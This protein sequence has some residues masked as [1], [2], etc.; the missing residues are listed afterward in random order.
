M[1]YVEAAQRRRD[2]EKRHQGGTAFVIDVTQA[3]P[4]IWVSASPL[5]YVYG[6]VY[7]LSHQADYY[8]GWGLHARFILLE[9]AVM[10]CLAEELYCSL[11]FHDGKTD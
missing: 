5:W 3:Q 6:Y 7:G 11:L 2:P 1:K 4:A 9:T 8:E 10:D